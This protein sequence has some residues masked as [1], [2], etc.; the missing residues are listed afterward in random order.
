MSG[1]HENGLI[2]AFFDL[3]GTLLPLPSLERRFVAA[4]RY[5]R[6]IPAMNYV[7]WM[8]HAVRIAPQGV[9]RIAHTNKMYLHNVEASSSTGTLACANAAHPAAASASIHQYS[10]PRFF[11]AGIDRV[12][13]HVR[14]GHTVIL[15]TGTLE[16]L[17][18]QAAL[19]VTL[20][21]VARGLTAS[22]GVCATRLEQVGG[23]WTGRIAGEAIIAENKA[24]VMQRIAAQ[25]GFELSRS[26]A[27][28]DTANDRWMLGAV[29]RPT[30][31]NPS[32]KLERIAR[33]RSWPIMRWSE[34]STSIAEAAPEEK[35][36]HNL[37]CTA[38]PDIHTETLG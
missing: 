33:L 7:R 37:N 13:W 24:R 23:R 20:R 35:R 36:S 14:Q 2:A 32:R 38:V 34:S 16:P 6:A 30:V 19:A 17:A 3:D 18:Q 8:A 31:I 11:P 15:T 4:L 27:Y 21:L 5:R 10:A 25:C 29:G 12:A 22:I 9:A 1:S 28:G 26:Y